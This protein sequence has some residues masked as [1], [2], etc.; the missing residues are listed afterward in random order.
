MSV[1]SRLHQSIRFCRKLCLD[2][3]WVEPS[4]HTMCHLITNQE[5]DRRLTRFWEN[6]QCQD[7]PNLTQEEK[8]CKEQ[9]DKTTYRNDN[10]QFVVQLPFKKDSIELLGESRS[11]AL[12]QDISESSP[13]S[14]VRLNKDENLATLGCGIPS[15]TRYNMSLSIKHPL[16]LSPREPY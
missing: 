2:G 4:Q 10:G 11:T 16:R 7:R 9:F 14:V 12:L 3:F 13:D 8:M 5:L 15:M 1:R 6:E